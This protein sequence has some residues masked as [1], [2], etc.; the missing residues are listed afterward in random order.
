[1]HP[2]VEA[3]SPCVFYGGRVGSAIAVGCAQYAV[4]YPERVIVRAEDVAAMCGVVRMYPYPGFL[5]V[6]LVVRQ[7]I[8]D[9]DIAVGPEVERLRLRS[10]GVEAKHGHHK[11]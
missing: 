11:H 1:M 4:L 8:T 9:G 3:D 7:Y 2:C 5:G 6:R 10:G